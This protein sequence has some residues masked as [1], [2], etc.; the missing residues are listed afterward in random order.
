MKEMNLTLRP[1][2]LAEESFVF[3]IAVNYYC[4]YHYYVCHDAS[5]QRFGNTC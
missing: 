2:I 5:Q 4:T 3:H 1:N